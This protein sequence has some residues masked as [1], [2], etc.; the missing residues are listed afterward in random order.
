MLGFR[1]VWELYVNRGAE[2]SPS[3]PSRPSP[4]S[5]LTKAL[6]PRCV[7]STKATHVRTSLHLHHSIRCLTAGLHL[8]QLAVA[9]ANTA[10]GTLK[11]RNATASRSKRQKC[12][13]CAGAKEEN[14][15]ATIAR[16]V[17]RHGGL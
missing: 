5:S 8:N 3:Q 10:T 17:R 13:T 15:V 14:A 16:K 7:P 11:R 1:F 9:E 4:S 12:I 2:P 6:H